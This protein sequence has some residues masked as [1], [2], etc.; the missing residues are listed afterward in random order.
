MVNLKHLHLSVEGKVGFAGLRAFAARHEPSSTVL[1]RGWFYDWVNP[2]CGS[3]DPL[4]LSGFDLI[5]VQ[6]S[7]PGRSIAL[8]SRR[9]IGQRLPRP[10]LALR[11]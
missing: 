7:T 10:G 4:P 1:A 5:L 8:L 9:A 6:R 11:A 2:V 3:R